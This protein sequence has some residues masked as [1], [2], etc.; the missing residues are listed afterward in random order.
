MSGIDLN[1]NGAEGEN[2]GVNLI[3]GNEPNKKIEGNANKEE[4]IEKSLNVNVD[5][6]DGAIPEDLI[7]GSD[8]ITAGFDNFSIDKYKKW[9]IALIIAIV[10]F[11]ISLF[12]INS[13]NSEIKEKLEETDKELAT[14]AN[15][16]SFFTANVGSLPGG[17][18]PETPDVDSADDTD[19]VIAGDDLEN[20]DSGGSVDVSDLGIFSGDST[21]S[22]DDAE[23]TGSGDP[24]EDLMN[25]TNTFGSANSEVPSDTEND[26]ADASGLSLNSNTTPEALMTGEVQGDTGPAIWISM[27]PVLGYGL[28]RKKK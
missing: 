15:L 28:L 23:D 19:P 6:E 18:A 1:N 8:D 13:G 7:P 9:I 2:K 24:F 26:T 10:L 5:D 17:E 22:G 4:L 25:E 11:G 20:I 27:L 12:V 14:T 16:P 21:D 3:Y